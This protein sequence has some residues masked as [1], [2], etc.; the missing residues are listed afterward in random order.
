MRCEKIVY[1]IEDALEKGCYLPALALTLTIPD[2]CAKY[3]YKK[4]YENKETYNGKQ[5][6]GA[7]YSKWYDNNIRNTEIPIINS[8]NLS[9]QELLIQKEFLEKSAITGELVWR[10]RCGLLHNGVLDLDKQWSDEKNTVKFKFTVSKESKTN[11]A[12]GA[13]KSISD[14]N[15]SH[16]NYDIQLDLITFCRKIL[17]VFKNCYLNKKDFLEYTER[18]ALNFIEI[19]R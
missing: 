3:D 18:D 1:A 12:G 16:A 2:I 9:K 4:I 10:L 7:A 17:A 6:N 19:E 15:G 5:G 14:F 13:S 8:K 11:F